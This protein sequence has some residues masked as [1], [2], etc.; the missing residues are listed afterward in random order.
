MKK[1]L[2][3]LLLIPINILAR[4]NITAE[5]NCKDE[6]VNLN[7]STNCNL[8]INNPNKIELNSVKFKIDSNLKNI[9][10]SEK[11]T[12]TNK[13]NEYHILIN[14]S[15]SSINILNF[16]LEVTEFESVLSFKDFYLDLHATDD[17]K[18][19]DLT[20][21]VAVKN[22][23]Y[24][25]KIMINNQPLDNFKSETYE[26]KQL[27]YK[28][29]DYVEVKV[30]ACNKCEIDDNIKLISANENKVQ[31]TVTNGNSVQN[32]TINLE[33]V[34]NT[35]LL[36]NIRI[37]E[38]DFTFI[39]D[40]FN[41]SFVVPNEIKALIFN[42][43]GNTDYKTSSTVLNVGENI[44]TVANKGKNITYTFKIK[45]LAEGEIIND[46][47]AVKSLKIG[48]SSIALKENIYEYSTEKVENIEVKLETA[49]PESDY[50][51]EYNEDT[52]SITVYNLTGK[53]QTYKI[54][55]I[56]ENIKDIEIEKYDNTTTIII[57]C[58][59]AALFVLVSLILYLKHKEYRKNF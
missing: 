38:I 22:A 45:R 53:S 37:E 51:V 25:T 1:L 48:H 26:Y 27:I 50:Y 35:D 11:F 23:A 7:Q 42:Y 3:I 40:K 43:S 16:D 49:N 18:L 5:I 36:E 13:N 2:L 32:Y 19:E 59:F 55:L 12:L 4:E 8:V 21:K 47:L 28:K 44:I 31:F 20:Q 34:D 39:E 41:Y 52:I 6:I 17:L 29:S 24:L 9:S 56:S 10:T 30:E 33:Y 57:V 58:I 54:N 15:S 46:E 14:D